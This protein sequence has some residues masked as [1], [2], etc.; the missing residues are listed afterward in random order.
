MEIL[1]LVRGFSKTQ[2]TNVGE[3]KA[4]LSQLRALVIQEGGQNSEYERALA[5]A[6]RLLSQSESVPEFLDKLEQAEQAQ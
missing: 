3:M 5:K 4:L 2:A 1:S 6:L